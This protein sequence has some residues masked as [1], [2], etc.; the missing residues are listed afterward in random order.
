VGQGYAAAMDRPPPDPSKLLAFWT[1]WELGETPPGR[2]IANLKTGG[3]RELL[4]LAA[5]V[6]RE[7]QEEVGTEV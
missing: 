2:V 1:E 7:A 6:Q 5:K 3:L 4:E